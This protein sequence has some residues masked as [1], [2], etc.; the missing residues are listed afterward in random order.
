LAF[1][2]ATATLTAPILEA[3]GIPVVRH[4]TA[5]VLPAGKF[6]ISTNCSGISTFY[7]AVFVALTLAAQAGTRTRKVVL[8][9][10]PWPITV[11]ANAIRSAVLLALCNRY[12]LEIINTPLHGLSGIGAFWG[13][14]LL[15]FALAS[16]PR[17]WKVGP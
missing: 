14:M 3:F 11:G 5:F 13:A 7:A 16:H 2:S 15:I 1:P 6:L 17:S 12:G 9:L 4:Q 8:L 10:S